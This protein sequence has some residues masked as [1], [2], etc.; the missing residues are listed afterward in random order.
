MIVA[1]R[2]AVR[3]SY[4][5]AALAAFAVLRDRSERR[6]AT[7]LVVVLAIQM[8]FLAFPEG[9]KA[10]YYLVTPLPFL[11]LLIGVFF[12][13]ALM[14]PRVR[15]IIVVWLGLL[16]LSTVGGVFMALVRNEIETAYRPVCRIVSAASPDRVV[17][18][19]EFAFCLGFEGP[20]TDDSHLGFYSGRAPD[21]FILDERYRETLSSAAEQPEYLAYAKALIGESTVI[22]QNRNYVVY[23]RAR[24]LS[25]PM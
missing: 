18:S 1:S 2:V 17:G 13:R 20:L 7:L 3:A 16:V 11:A 10:Q 12:D 22:H 19:A 5:I 25:R 8:A 24:S 4:A 23:R 6:V 14:W 21:V 9:N 15:P